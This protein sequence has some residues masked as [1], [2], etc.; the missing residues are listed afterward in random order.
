MAKLYELAGELADIL[1]VIEDTEGEITSEIE[2]RLDQ[3]NEAFERKVE[4][5]CQ[6][7]AEMESRAAVLAA[8]ADQFQAEAD[9]I[10]AKAKTIAGKADWVKSYLF[11]A[12]LA[13]GQKKIEAGTFTLRVQKN[14][15]PAVKLVGEMIP[16][17]FVRIVKEFDRQKALEAWKENQSV[18]AE[19]ARHIPDPKLVDQLAP[20]PQEVR[21][22]EGQH[23][24]IT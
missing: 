9:R 5:L 4:S 10:R 18:R 8:Q 1:R 17:Q 12:M 6:W 13:V 20:F 15:Q 21:V 22:I 24:R 19:L 2:S 3:V 11:G 7:R 14:S 23:L 16:T